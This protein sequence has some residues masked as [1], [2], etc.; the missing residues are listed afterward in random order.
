MEHMPA[1]ASQSTVDLASPL[2]SR[3]SGVFQTSP[4]L[5]RR[6]ALGPWAEAIQQYLAI[7]LGDPVRSRGCYRSFKRMVE[8]LP[9]DELLAPPGLRAQLYHRARSVAQAELTMPGGARGGTLGWR[10][11]DTGHSRLRAE[12]PPS[13]AELLELRHARELTLEELAFVV[14]LPLD[15]AELALDT[16]EARARRILAGGAPDPSSTLR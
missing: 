14:E 7:R 11:K 1:S 6:R 4:G 10:S 16:A 15:A 8:A 12:L 13:D 3:D 2:E 9:P 5:L